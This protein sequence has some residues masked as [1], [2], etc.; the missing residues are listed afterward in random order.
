MT[1]ISEW[2][3]QLTQIPTVGEGGEEEREVSCTYYTTY[4]TRRRDRGKL[5]LLHYLLH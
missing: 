1:T 4:Y 5:Y 2:W 3:K